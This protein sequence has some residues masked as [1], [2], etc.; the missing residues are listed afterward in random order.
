[1][2]DSGSSQAAKTISSRKLPNPTS[3]S[4]R[5]RCQ[6]SGCLGEASRCGSVPRP[7]R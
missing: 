7:W 5:C 3:Q 6:R 2:A 1:M 4:P